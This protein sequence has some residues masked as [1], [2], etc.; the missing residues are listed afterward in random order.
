[1]FIER[2]SRNDY[3]DLGIL[4]ADAMLQKRHWSVGL[5]I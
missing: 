1:M 3:A 4:D 5:A 2:G